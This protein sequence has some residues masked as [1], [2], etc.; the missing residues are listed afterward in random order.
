MESED[1]LLEQRLVDLQARFQE[2]ENLN[3]K[4][5]DELYTLLSR[6][7]PGAAQPT[8]KDGN[9][10]VQPDAGAA[11]SA[12]NG[13]R[14]YGE[15]IFIVSCLVTVFEGWVLWSYL[16]LPTKPTILQILG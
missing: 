5:E 6:M 10:P 2:A 8:K 16:I 15:N 3:K 4:R 14:R 13:T 11:A 9:L 1:P 7:K 12:G